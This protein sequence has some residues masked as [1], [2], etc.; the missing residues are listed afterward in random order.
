[1]FAA[2]FVLVHIRVTDTGINGIDSSFYHFT[3]GEIGNVLLHRPLT[4]DF[5]VIDGVWISEIVVENV[6]NEEKS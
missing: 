6:V 1:M 3:A 5:G 2:A 4:D